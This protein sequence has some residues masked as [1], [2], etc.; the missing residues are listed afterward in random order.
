[1]PLIDLATSTDSRG[2]KGQGHGLLKICVQ[3]VPE[4]KS[5]TQVDLNEYEML[6]KLSG[7]HSEI[8]TTCVGPCTESYNPKEWNFASNKRGESVRV[9]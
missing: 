7:E 1:M 3:E 2:N 9:M 6:N 4:A 8:Q 5:S